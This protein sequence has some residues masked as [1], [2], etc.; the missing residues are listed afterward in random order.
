MFS[1]NYSRRFFLAAAPACLGVLRAQRKHVPIGLLIYAVLQD[2]KKNPEGTLEAL[3]HFGYEGVELTQ[4]ESWTP[5]YARRIR[6]VADG[7]HLKIFATH[8][9]PEYFVPGDKMKAMI[10]LNQ[11]LGTQTVCCVRGVA[12]GSGVG[13]RAKSSGVNGWKE[14]ADVLE[15]ACEVLRKDRMSCSFHNHPV[16]FRGE[17]GARLIDV[18]AKAPDLKF[19]IDV[20]VARRAGADLVAFCRQYAGRIDSLLLTD[21]PADANQHVPLLGKGDTPWAEILGAAETV[22]GVQFYLLTHGAA[23]WPP[24]ETAKRDL[25]QYRLLDKR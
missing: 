7:F 25:E 4:Y 22:G 21:G 2:W 23:E 18:L 14:L 13:Y 11:M 16:E 6:A 15:A 20:N 19:H 9:E 8:T 5:D 1:N 24:M 10:E 3:A 12:E 17:P